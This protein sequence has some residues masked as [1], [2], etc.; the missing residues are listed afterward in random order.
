VNFLRCEAKDPILRKYPI[1]YDHGVASIGGFPFFLSMSMVSLVL[2]E[3]GVIQV[4]YM[5]TESL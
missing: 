4:P 5:M 1:F 2:Q 3:T